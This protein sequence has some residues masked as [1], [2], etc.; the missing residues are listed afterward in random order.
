MYEDYFRHM[1]LGCCGRAEP[2]PLPPAE[3]ERVEQ[4]EEPV[5]VGN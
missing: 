1:H 4:V 5:P 3:P 2:A